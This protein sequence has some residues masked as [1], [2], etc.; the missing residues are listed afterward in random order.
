MCEYIHYTANL[1]ISGGIQSLI[2]T[3]QFS[4][5]QSQAY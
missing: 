3:K 1:I 5:S 4:E 2:S